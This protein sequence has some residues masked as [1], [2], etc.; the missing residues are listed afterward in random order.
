MDADFGVRRWTLSVRRLVNK[1][2][3]DRHYRASSML[4][5]FRFERSHVDREAVFHVGLEQ[6]FIGFVD[7]LDWNDFDI[8]GDVM[9]AAK[10]E[11]LLRFGDT[12]DRRAGQ[13]VSAEDQAEG[14]NRERFLRCADE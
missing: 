1:I 4:G 2:R 11:H 6:S 3:S 9:L 10:I 8:G 14:R 13:A 7:F 12:A 5:L